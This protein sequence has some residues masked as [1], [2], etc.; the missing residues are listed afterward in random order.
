MCARSYRFHDLIGDMSVVLAAGLHLDF[1]QLNANCPVFL[2]V[3][4]LVCVHTDSKVQ[5]TREGNRQSY[6][7]SL[8]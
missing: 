1:K 4:G 5:T 6:V 2:L 8:E 3:D 7:C